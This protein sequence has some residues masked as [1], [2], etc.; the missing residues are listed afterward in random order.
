MDC[1][2]A[3]LAEKSGWFNVSGLSYCLPTCC[4]PCGGTPLDSDVDPTQDVHIEVGNAVD[5][6]LPDAEI[7]PTISRHMPHWPRANL[8]MSVGQTSERAEP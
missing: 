2:G 1:M 8:T 4:E 6:V 3:I 7:M 5:A